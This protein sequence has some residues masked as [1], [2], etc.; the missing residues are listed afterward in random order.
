M[1]CNEWPLCRPNQPKS[2]AIT[3]NDSLDGEVHSETE[4]VTVKAYGSHD[5]KTEVTEPTCTEG[6]YT[7][8]TCTR[9]GDT[10]TADETD[11]LGHYW[12]EWK[13][14]TPATVTADG[15]EQRICVRCD[16]LESRVIPKTESEAH[17]FEGG[18]CPWCGETHN[19]KTVS[20]WWTE[21]LHHILYIF[22][23]IFLWWTPFAK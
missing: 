7:T 18:P 3:A 13:V 4:N 9:C 10:Y 5:Y 19:I 6:G 1:P 20:G 23:R 11:A 16:K 21:L 8:Y 12:S 14:I 17:P 22:N 2:A 15:L